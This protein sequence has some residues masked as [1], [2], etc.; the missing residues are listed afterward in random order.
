MLAIELRPVACYLR[1][2]VSR[3]VHSADALE[4]LATNPLPARAGIVT[5]LP[6]VAEFG[7][8]DAERWQAWFVEA[9]RAVL[10]AVPVEGAAVFFQ[11]DVKRDGRWV[12]KAFL[13]Q[14]AASEVGVPLVW[15]KIVCRAPAG[16]ATGG[17]PGYAH[18]L[19]FSREVQDLGDAQADVLPELGG[20]TWPKGMGRAAA[21]FAVRWLVAAGAGLVVAPF[22]GE[23]T[24]LVAANAVGLD[25]VGIELNPGRAARAAESRSR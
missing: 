19:C 21:D 24:A 14:Q 7:H 8:R 1:A 9:A 10:R 17:R 3:I 18:L 11:T 22:C 23:G 5:S 16:Q 13:V 25:A 12:D 2:M 15:H 6:D 4:W 20:Q